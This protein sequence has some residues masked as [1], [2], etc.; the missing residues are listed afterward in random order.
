MRAILIA[1][2]MALTACGG[3][4]D[5]ATANSPECAE[6]IAQCR[7]APRSY[8]ARVTYGDG[9]EGTPLVWCYKLG[10]GPLTPDGAIYCFWEPQYDACFPPR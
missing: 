2:A 7:C 8:M 1:A 9:D 4:E 3:A 10:G 5:A 6:A